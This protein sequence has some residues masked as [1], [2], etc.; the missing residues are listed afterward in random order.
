MKVKIEIIS[1]RSICINMVHCKGLII[2]FTVS[3][4]HYNILTTLMS[5]C[6]FS[7]GSCVAFITR[8]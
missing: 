4:H 3:I 7:L 2:M 6:L 1:L 5:A 8:N